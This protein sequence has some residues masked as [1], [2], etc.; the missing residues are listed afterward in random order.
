MPTISALLHV[1][2]SGLRAATFGVNVSS[3]N[4]MNAATP[5]YSRRTIAQAPFPGPPEGGNG[6]TTKGPMRI[7]DRFLDRRLLGATSRE[8]EA[9]ARHQ[10]T[11][12]LDLTLAEGTASIGSALDAFETALRDVSASPA[13]RGL[14]RIVLD[15]AGS[16]AQAFRQAGQSIVDAREEADRRITDGVGEVNRLTTEIDRL[17]REI[18]RSEVTGTEASDL[19]D[20]RDQHVRELSELVPVDVLDGRDGTVTVLLNGSL[21]LVNADG[22]TGKLTAAASTADGHMHV[23]RATAGR[24]EDVTGLLTGGRLGGQIAGRDGALLDAQTALDALAFDVATAW[25]SVHQ[26]GVGL[27]GVSGR[28]LFSTPATATDAARLLAVDPAVLGNPDAVAAALDPALVPGDNRNALAL[29]AVAGQPIAS[30]GTRT[31]SAALADVMAVAGS[32]VRDAQAATEEWGAHKSQIATLRESV[33]GTS[34][35][36]EMVALMSYQR[37]YEASLRVVQVA[38]DMLSQLVQLGRR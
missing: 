34:S 24:I 12:V 4:A 3:Q 33:S 18:R 7:V 17:Q 21:A 28:A 35:D 26:A 38:D 15:S 31:A 13:D 9:S 2:A 30:G 16:V 20:Q 14:R 36:D 22:G 19:R 10:L 23:Y 5:G 37:A 25:N 6:V 11:E 32:A 1:G 27:D 8:S 29:V